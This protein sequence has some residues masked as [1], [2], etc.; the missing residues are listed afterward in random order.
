M[1]AIRERHAELTVEADSAEGILNAVIASPI[2]KLNALHK[3]LPHVLVPGGV[4]SGGPLPGGAARWRRSRR[5]VS[6]RTPPF[7]VV[8]MSSQLTR[9]LVLPG[10]L[11]VSAALLAVPATAQRPRA[12]GPA[13]PQRLIEPA[14][15]ASLRFRYVGPEGNRVASVA[16]VIGDRRV[17][18][19]GAASGGIWKTEDAGLTWRPVFDDHPVS[20]IGAL[21]VAASDPNVVWAGTGEPHVRSHISVGWG[22]YKSTDAGATWRL[23]GLEATGRVSRVVVHPTNPDLVYVAALGHAYGPQRERG[24]YRT[25]D[26]GRTWEQVLF[27]DERTGASELVMDPNN[28]RILFAGFWQIDIK[29]WGRESGGPGSSIWTSRDG[30]ATWTRLAGHGLPARPYGKVALGIAPT[31]SNRVYAM[32]E[33]GDGVPWH[34]QPTDRGKLWRSD[35]GGA[36]WEVVSYDRQLGGRSAYY[37]AMYVAPDDQDEAYFLTA[38]FSRTLD[39][40]RTTTG[41]GFGGSPGGDNHVMWIDPTDANRMAVANDGGISISENRGRTWNRINL[42]IAQMY[43]VTTDHRVPYYVMG[44]RQDGPST[45]G[46]SNSKLGGFGGGSIPRGLFHGVGGGESGWATPDPGDSNIVWSSA[47]GSGSRGGI[48][49]RHD[50]RTGVSRS[51]EVWPVSTGGWPPADLRYRFVW[52]F[53]L[54][55]SPH[56]PNTLYVGSQHVHV[57]T[58][59]GNSW[60]EVSPDLTRNDKSRMRISGGLTPDNIGV[61]YGGVIFAIAES[62]R[63]KGLIWVGTND[64]LVHVTRDGGSTWTNVTANLPGLPEWGTISNIEPSPHAAGTAYLSVDGHQVD[65]REPWIYRTTD[66]GR[67]WRLIVDGIPKSPLSYVHVVREDPFRRG[68]L[69]A[70]TENGLYL[71]FDA[72]DHWQPFQANLPPAPVYWLTI[73]EH[74]KDLVIATYGRGFWILDDLSALHQ[75][76]PEVVASEA[77]FF[78]PRYAYRFQSVTAPETPASDPVV[79]QNPAYGAALDYWLKAPGPVTFTIRDAEGGTVRTLRATG[80]AGLNRATWDLTH[81]PTP[82]ARLRVSPLYAPEI[83]VPPEGLPAPGLGQMAMLAVPGQYTVTLRAGAVEQ[84]RT[85]EVRK[86]PNSGGSLDGIAAQAGLLRQVRESYAEAVGMINRLELIRRQLAELEVHAEAAGGHRDLLGAADSLAAAV[87]AVEEQL[88]QVRATG[89]G[90]DGVRWPVKLAGQLL[91]LGQAVTGS[92]E[93]PTTQAREAYG[94]LAGQLARTKAEFDKALTAAREFT[95]VLARRNLAAPIP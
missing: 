25:T 31:N 81:D 19:A 40:G 50:L 51:V 11:L 32:I 68:L 78:E 13:Q 92:D 46:P 42:P 56:N 12:A 77:H 58:D 80:R 75:L 88:H 29:T 73:Q 41:A 65:N 33:A 67:T 14:S 44:N 66:Y 4:I 89:R 47:S 91:Y 49:V 36:T 20:S 93:G 54:T 22:V 9:R 30:G 59:Q 85:L 69:Y 5:T 18:Y 16:G 79:G 38:G 57:T 94:H 82:Q 71:S 70:G 3:N 7:G 26:G 55:F 74:F 1:A 45:R 60:R 23:M 53:P 83:E 72:G 28:P 86:D 76:T 37:N 27:V 10:A 84:T 39:G 95:A 52:T 64:G 8:P 87:L 2:A 21:A 17:Y 35:D 43:H 61:E 62:R 48:V 24:I 34:G 63:E 90:Q 15:Y 6:S